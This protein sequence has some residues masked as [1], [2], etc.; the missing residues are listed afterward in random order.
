MEVS[1]VGLPNSRE[2]IQARVSGRVEC[3]KCWLGQPGWKV[4][5]RLVILLVR[6]GS[7]STEDRGFFLRCDR[8][9]VYGRGGR[10]SH[11]DPSLNEAIEPSLKGLAM[12]PL[13]GQDGHQFPSTFGITDSLES[14]DPGRVPED[15]AGSGHEV[16]GQAVKR[17]GA[18]F[19]HLAPEPA[20]RPADAPA[21]RIV[22]GS[23]AVAGGD[24]FQDE[25]VAILGRG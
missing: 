1:E 2:L 4:L 10:I 20:E 24:D 21:A 19:G 25:V 5:W 9:P 12:D 13:L 14:M 8:N 23:V 17:R 18:K 16:I 11:L 7:S 3:P 15:R 6:P 22:C